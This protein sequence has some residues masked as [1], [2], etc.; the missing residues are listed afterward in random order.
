VIHSPTLKI[1]VGFASLKWGL[2][3]QTNYNKINTA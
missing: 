3:I 2:G 1:I